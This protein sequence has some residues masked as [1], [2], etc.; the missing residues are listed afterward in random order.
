M[1]GFTFWY[2]GTD[3]FFESSKN[4]VAKSDLNRYARIVGA[5]PAEIKREIQK[6]KCEI[7]ILSNGKKMYQ[8]YGENRSG[9]KFCTF[10][11]LGDGTR[12]F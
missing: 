12:I 2:R 3:Y 6:A 8:I 10:G 11:L 4:Y 5:D 9:Y 1:N 7:S